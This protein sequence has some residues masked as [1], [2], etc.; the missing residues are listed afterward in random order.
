M[1]PVALAGKTL[2]EL[3]NKRVVTTIG[4]TADRLIKQASMSRGISLRSIVGRNQV[5]S[6]KMLENGNADVYVGDDAVLAG[7]RAAQD[8]PEKYVILDEGY[9]V[10]PYGIVLP[11]DD[12]QFKQLVDDVLIGL[13]KS[14]EIEKIYNAW[15]MSPTPPKNHNLNLPMSPLN[16]AAFTN[17]S[18][19]SVN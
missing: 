1:V 12:P 17:P 11:K 3:G 5:D 19:R 16:K 13:M 9:S 7:I 18:D 4:S 6:M 14:G 8:S 10:E 2:K 15:F